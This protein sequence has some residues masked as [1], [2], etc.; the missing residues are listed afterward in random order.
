VR[1]STRLPRRFMRYTG[2][3]IVAFAT[4]E[5]VLVVCYA[6]GVLGARGATI[7]AF[8]AGAVPNY[9]LN[10]HWVWERRGRPTIGR[11]V[12]LYVAVSVLSLVAAIVATRWATEAVSGDHATRTLAAAAAYL[13]AYACLFV[14]KFAVFETV[15]FSPRAVT[16]RKGRSSAQSQVRA[17]G[18]DGI[19]ATHRGEHRVESVADVTT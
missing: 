3:S 7:A 18:F 13:I 14:A 6:S 11:E 12:V 9:A 17:R 4:S 8:F 19:R 10:R 15:V 16:A 2:G 1:W 5:V